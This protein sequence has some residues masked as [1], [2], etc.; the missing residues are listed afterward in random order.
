MHRENLVRDMEPTDDELRAYY[1]ANRDRIAVKEQRRIR[2]VVLPTREQADDIKARIDAG[3]ITIYQAA[4]EH[5][6]DPNAKQTL[7]D[8]GWVAKGTGF[9]GLDKVTFALGFDELG[10]PVES[11][12]GWHLVKV[13]DTRSSAF[14][15]FDEEDTRTV[16]RRSFLKQQLGDYV[17][18]L[19]KDEF[20]VVVYEENLNRMFH[21]EA[22]WIA[23]KTREMAENPEKAKQLLGELRDIVE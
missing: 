7:G 14:T 18:E 22:Q 21:D 10:G 16:A 3:E 17:K 12:A 15:D 2:M 23:A 20:P 19:R 9:P 8:F 5:S 4:V 1:E 6:I 11:P 13:L